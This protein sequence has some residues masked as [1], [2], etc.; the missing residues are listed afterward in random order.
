[1]SSQKKKLNQRFNGGFISFFIAYKLDQQGTS[2]SNWRIPVTKCLF[3]S[4]SLTSD[5]TAPNDYMKNLNLLEEKSLSIEKENSL[6]EMN[7]LEM[8]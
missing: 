3:E 8:Q 5:S 6:Y 1:M 4:C 7:I 2:F